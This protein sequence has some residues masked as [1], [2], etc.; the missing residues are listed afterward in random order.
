MT[1]NCHPTPSM[2]WLLWPSFNKI[3]ERAP[4]HRSCLIRLQ[5]RRPHEFEHYLRVGDTTYNHRRQYL[6]FVENEPRRVYWDFSPDKTIDSNEPRR[7][8]P[9]ESPSS[10][11]PLP[12]R[13]RKRLNM[14]RYFPQKGRVSQHI[15]EACG[16]PLP[17]RKTP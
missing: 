3:R 5:S 14:G 13:Q 10:T 7:M 16:Q 2:C 1:S 9:A 4:N 11:P 12:P 6:L 8:S 17:E 15:C